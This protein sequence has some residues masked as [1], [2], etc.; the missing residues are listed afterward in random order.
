M[1]VYFLVANNNKHIVDNITFGFI[2]LILCCL[3]VVSTQQPSTGEYIK[4]QNFQMLTEQ[5]KNR[6][7][8][9]HQTEMNSCTLQLEWEI[10]TSYIA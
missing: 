8:P 10:A 5:E 4:T 3:L 6:N 1:F 9:N 2:Q 7:T